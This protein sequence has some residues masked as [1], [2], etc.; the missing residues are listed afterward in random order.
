[1]IRPSV[2]LLA[3]LACAYQTNHVATGQVSALWGRGSHEVLRGSSNDKVLH[4]C[5]ELCPLM[6]LI[7]H[8]HIHILPKTDDPSGHRRSLFVLPAL[9]ILDFG[10]VGIYHGLV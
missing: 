8:T 4:G 10:L 6:R 3:V 1:M 9:H 7:L 2:P 5:D